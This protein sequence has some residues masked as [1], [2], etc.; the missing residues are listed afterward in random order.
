MS[1]CNRNFFYY[2]NNLLPT[3]Q[4]SDLIF[5]NGQFIYDVIRIVKGVPLFIDQY[6]SRLINT[7]SLAN[8][9]L[10]IS[11]SEILNRIN[12][13]ITVND[14]VEDSLKLVFGF[15]NS[16]SEAETKIFLAYFM[17]NNAPTNEQFLIGVNTI[18]QFAKRNNPHAKVINIA[19]RFNANLLINKTGAY[20]TI[21]VN[22]N[23]VI[24]EGSRSNVFFIKQN[25]VYTTSMDYVLPGV[26]RNN[27]IQLCKE[28][29]IPIY[30]TIIDYSEA[31]TFE[32]M[33]ITG[34]SRKILPVYLYDNYTF[35]VNNSLLRKLMHLYNLKIENYINAI[36]NS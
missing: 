16:E 1:E 10:W 36:S 5:N 29:G 27:T 21:L 28:N 18:S 9:T 32:A 8:M 17:K 20:E 2:N 7:A 4:F 26:T 14:V 33:F 11:E 34:T 35:N 23:N 12:T 24:T 25:G 30:E 31:Q 19:L 22:E 3:E 13:L 6:L 15:T